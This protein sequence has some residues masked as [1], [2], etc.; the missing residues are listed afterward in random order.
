[1]KHVARGD[2][3]RLTTANES[4]S[5]AREQYH[6]A[7]ESKRKAIENEAIKQKLIVEKQ[8]TSLHKKPLKLFTKRRLYIAM[9]KQQQ[10]RFELLYIRIIHILHKTSTFL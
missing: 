10:M 4:L 6:E 5:S 2:P 1:M 3:D 7:V 9:R 8:A